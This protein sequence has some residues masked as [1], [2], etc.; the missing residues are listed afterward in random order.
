MREAEPLSVLRSMGRAWVSDGILSSVEVAANSFLKLDLDTAS[1]VTIMLHAHGR[2]Y[3]WAV[4]VSAALSAKER[5]RAMV[6]RFQV[7]ERNV[8]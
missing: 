6:S 1:I 3:L 8:G 7:K 4:V 5:A 2:C